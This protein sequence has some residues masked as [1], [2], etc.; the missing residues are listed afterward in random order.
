M[1]NMII[2]LWIA[3][4]LTMTGCAGNTRYVHVGPSWAALNDMKTSE[5]TFRVWVWGPDRADLGDRIDFEVQSEQSGRLWVVQVDPHDELTV[6]W[7]NDKVKDNR[8]EAQ[9]RVHI[10]PQGADW[11]IVAGEPA[12]QSVVAFI[13]TRGDVDLADVLPQDDGMAK[14]LSLVSETPNWGLIK[15][16]IDVKGKVGK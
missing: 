6:L 4:A 8:I 12:G 5:R 7:P 11:S 9:T 16:V 13:V 3:T 15:R 10:P 2:W 14:A 1:K